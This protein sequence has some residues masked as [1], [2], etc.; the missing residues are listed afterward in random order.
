MY[1]RNGVHCD[2]NPHCQQRGLRKVC[3]NC[4]KGRMKL[5]QKKKNHYIF[6]SQLRAD[7]TS[8]PPREGQLMCT[9]FL[10]MHQ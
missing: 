4:G 7:Q 2:Q 5:S 6:S 10:S 1:F 3:N 9:L 8:G